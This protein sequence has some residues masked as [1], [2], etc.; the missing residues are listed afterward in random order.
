MDYFVGLEKLPDGLEFPPALR[1]RIRYDAAARRLVYHGFMSKADF[2]RL[3]QLSEDWSYRRQLE[4]LFR[5]STSDGDPPPRG[6]RRVISSL[7]RAWLA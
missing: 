3:C 6:L 1:D 7:A 2:D 4:E 5:K